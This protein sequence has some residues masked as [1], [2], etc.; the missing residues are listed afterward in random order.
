MK[1]NIKLSLLAMVFCLSACTSKPVTQENKETSTDE[2]VHVEAEV[3]L[4]Q[5]LEQETEE[6]NSN[7]IEKD[8]IEEKDQQNVQQ[9]KPPVQSNTSDNVSRQEKETPKKETTVEQTTIPE[10]KPQEKPSVPDAAVPEVPNIPTCSFNIPDG[11]YSSENEAANYAESVILD[12]LI[13]GDG[14]LT[15]YSIERAQTECGTPYYI[16]KIY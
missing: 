5:K 11:T 1:K 8:S 9:Q 12:N 4:S 10:Q 6:N 16:L 7:E 2:K 15:G 13:N 14:S 3:Q